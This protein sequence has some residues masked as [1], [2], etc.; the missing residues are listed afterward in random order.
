[1]SY[2]LYGAN[3]KYITGAIRNAELVKVW[4]PG[5]V[6]RFYVDDT[7]PKDKIATLQAKGAEIISM[8]SRIKGGIAGMFWRFLV[9]DD[10]TVDRW[11][12]RDS[13]SR[14]NPRERFAVEEWIRSGKS[15]H[16]IR[17][18]PNHERP[19]NGGLWGG[20]R[21]AIRGS[22]TEMVKAFPNKEAYGGD[23]QFLG[24]ARVASARQ[25]AR[26]ARS[27]PSSSAHKTRAPRSASGRSSRTIRSP[28]TRTRAPNFRIRT[29]SRPR[30]QQTTSTSDR[31]AASDKAHADAWHS[32]APTAGVRRKRPAAHG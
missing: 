9:A 17:D 8:G 6:A 21:G 24:E 5:W 26:G 14:L 11:I 3:P 23:L 10:A 31:S 7:V 29:H 19:L 13:D 16:T 27:A 22:M 18:H 30:G 1:M 28:T 32:H 15:V 4:F 2:G 12:V 20:V 25:C